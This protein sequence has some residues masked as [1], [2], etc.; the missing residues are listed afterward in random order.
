[1]GGGPAPSPVTRTGNRLTGGSGADTLSGAEAQDRLTGGS[2]SDI[3]TGGS[4]NDRIFAADNR[5]DS[6][7]CGPGRD[8]AVIDLIEDLQGAP[9]QQFISASSCETW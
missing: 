3:L 7:D 2:G 4:G 9:L 1:M 8:T 5:S 6:I